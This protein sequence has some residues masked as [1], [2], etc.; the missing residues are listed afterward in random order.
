V[1]KYFRLWANGVLYEL[2]VLPMGACF[3]PGIAQTIAEGALKILRNEDDVDAFVYVDKWDNPKGLL[4]KQPKT[5][6]LLTGGRANTH[7]KI[8]TH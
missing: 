6:A 3:C 4:Y 5:D 2:N 7:S 1:R 8:T